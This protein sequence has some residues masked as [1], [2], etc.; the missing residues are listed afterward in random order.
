M[1]S[2]QPESAVPALLP[3]AAVDHEETVGGE[4]AIDAPVLVHQS[5]NTIIYRLHTGTFIKVAL[6]PLPS[7]E[8]VVRLLQEQSVAA[9]LPE[10]VRKREVLGAAE[11]V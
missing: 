9:F 6:D 2:G 4:G 10:T 1:D 8:Q 7:Q 3:P 11:A 5:D